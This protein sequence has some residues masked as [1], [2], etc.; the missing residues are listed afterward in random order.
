MLKVWNME[1]A[2]GRKVANQFVI[3]TGSTYTFQSYN[4]TIISIDFNNKL[5]VVY[6]EWD[7]SRTT[8]KYRNMF[9]REYFAALDSKSEMEKAIASG[10]VDGFRVVTMWD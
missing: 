5:I 3:T 1:S 4:S 6:R 2:S 10:M 8:A 7:Y 9:M